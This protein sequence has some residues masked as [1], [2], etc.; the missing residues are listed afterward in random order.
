MN[1]QI[2]VRIP[3]ELVEALDRLA[4]QRGARRSEVVRQALRAYLER[5]PAPEGERPFDRVRDLAGS[6]YGG[7]PD[8]AARHREYLKE[9]F[10]GE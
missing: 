9:I 10:G 6:V 5:P 1:A 8:L 2:T 4:A 7:P 3:Q